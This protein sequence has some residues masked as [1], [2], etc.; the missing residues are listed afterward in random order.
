MSIKSPQRTTGV[1]PWVNARNQNE[2]LPLECHGRQPVGIY[3]AY[4]NLRIGFD[5]VETA[6]AAHALTGWE[7]FDS[8]VLE[9]AHHEDLITTKNM[10][11]DSAAFSYFGDWE[12][13]N[14]RR[15]S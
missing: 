2:L 4:G 5:S 10:Q 9:V 11:N 12:I 6:Q 13:I 7:C 14:H 15:Q 1:S 8:A 3:S